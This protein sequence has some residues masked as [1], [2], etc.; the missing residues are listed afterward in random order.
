MVMN[1]IKDISKVIKLFQELSLPFLVVV[2]QFDR[3]DEDEREA[4]QNSIRRE[5]DTICPG[6]D[7]FFI[8]AKTPHANRQDWDRLV[9]ALTPPPPPPYSSNNQ[10]QP[11]V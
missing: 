8:S 4:F 9:N 11:E 3:V 5:R 1:T 6:V 2:N 7:V 10:S